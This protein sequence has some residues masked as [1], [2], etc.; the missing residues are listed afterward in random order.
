MA[1]QLERNIKVF[2][3]EIAIEVPAERT[4]KEV[5]EFIYDA[6]GTHKYLITQD[7]EIYGS[8]NPMAESEVRAVRN[9]DRMK[10]AH[11]GKAQ[12]SGR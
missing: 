4:E 1:K 12:G 11:N 10:G 9:V 5:R 8:P 3:F 7:P 2:K 6:L